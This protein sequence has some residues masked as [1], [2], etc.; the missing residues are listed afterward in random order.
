MSL[1]FVDHVTIRHGSLEKEWFNIQKSFVQNSD[2]SAV[3]LNGIWRGV[4]MWKN[5]LVRLAPRKCLRWRDDLCKHFTLTNQPLTCWI[6]AWDFL[7]STSPCSREAFS[8][9]SLDWSAS[10]SSS[11]FFLISC[12]KKH[13][14]FLNIIL[15]WSEFAN[16]MKQNCHHV[17]GCV[18]N[19]STNQSK[20][21]Y[22]VH[23]SSTTP[24]M[25][26][27][28]RLSLVYFRRR[29][30]TAEY[31]PM[32]AGRDHSSMKHKLGRL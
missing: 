7:I 18:Q 17:L 4:I 20:C 22:F 12:K 31:T 10:S 25:Q 28:S 29:Q 15:R 11:L 5:P 19:A 16:A 2:K 14:L 30:V 21:Y 27:Y 32:F 6:P 1:R 8:S 9:L 26:T 3:T 24:R 23:Q 13:N